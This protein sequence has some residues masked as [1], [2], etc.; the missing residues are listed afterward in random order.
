MIHKE[1]ASGG[2][3]FDTA[4]RN[5]CLSCGACCAAFR[6]SFYW[7]EGDDETP[8]GV[9]V[10][11]T[12]DLNATYRV[13]KGTR[14]LKPRCIALNGE[15]GVSVLCAIYGRRPTVCGEFPPSHENGEPHARCDKARTVHGLAVLCPD[16]KP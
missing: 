15:I 9:P 14:G 5:P 6:A 13:M 3:P 7:R 10:G 4:K 16:E 2:L 11:L 12:D 8:G 1:S